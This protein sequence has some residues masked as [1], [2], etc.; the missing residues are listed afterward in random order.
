MTK[1]FIYSFTA[2]MAIDLAIV[3]AQEGATKAAEGTLT[4]DKKSYQLGNAVAYESTIDD[5]DIVVAVLSGQPVASE[6]LKEARAAEKDGGDGDFKKPFLKLVFKKTGELKYWS[7][8]GGGTTMGRH[9]AGSA[10]AELK[11]SD[12]RANGKISQAAEADA[13]IPGAFDVRFNVALLKAGEELPASTP[14]VR[15]PAANV[16]PTVSGIFKG[17][18]KD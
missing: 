6:T 3:C 12:G 15:G 10:K 14:K 1:K 9:G 17:N 18:T 5:E 16:R 8:G 4:L 2:L 7:A 13:M 11:L